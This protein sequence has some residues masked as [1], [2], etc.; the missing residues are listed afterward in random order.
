[1]LSEGELVINTGR[2]GEGVFFFF[3]DKRVIIIIIIIIFF[4][5]YHQ[6]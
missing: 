4:C 6:A 3:F 5:L 2:I 1:M